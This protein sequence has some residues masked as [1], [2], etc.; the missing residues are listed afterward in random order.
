[1]AEDLLGVPLQVGDY[2][3][4]AF[5]EGNSSEIRF[6]RIIEEIAGNVRFY[7]IKTC[8]WNTNSVPDAFIKLAWYNPWNQSWAKSTGRVDGYSRR[9]IK[10][11]LPAHVLPFA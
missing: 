2:V 7:D 8:T 11:D 10:M 6:G 1:M 9:M 4:M 3:A 5:R